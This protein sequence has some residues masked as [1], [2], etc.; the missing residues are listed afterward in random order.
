MEEKLSKPRLSYLDF[1]RGIASLWMIEVHVVDICLADTLKQGFFYDMLNIS[2]GFVAVCF[3]F[4]AGAGFQLASDKKRDVYLQ[5]SKPLWTYLRRLGLILLIGYWLNLHA[6]S[7]QR[8][9]QSNYEEWL[10]IFKYDVLH[11]IVYSSLLA[12]IILFSIPNRN[13]RVGIYITLAI[14][15]FFA[16]PFIWGLDTVHT[17]PLFFS[18][19]FAKQPIGKFPMFHFGGY[20]FAG[21]AIT[22]IFVQIKD[23]VRFANIGLIVSIV[24]PFILFGL[25]YSSFDF[26]GHDDWWHASPGHALYRTSVVMAVM[27]LLY[28]IQ[29]RIDG[30]K[31]GDVLIL[32]GQESLFFY[33][34][35][36]MLVYGTI[37]NFGLVYLAKHRYNVFETA[38]VLVVISALT[39]SLASMWHWYKKYE[40]QKASRLLFWLIATFITVYILVPSYL[41]G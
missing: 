29:Q 10:Q 39:Y 6:F 12:L 36:L 7:L 17:L 27:F 19:W 28:K 13:A 20:F 15:F 4:C 8:T 41:A 9:L 40:P 25:K 32:A 23:K 26:P 3:I 21:A 35:H 37:A 33:V 31:F 5:F 2:N 18:T 16:T 1:L 11:N 30:T 34:F 24:L 38:L 22:A 14:V